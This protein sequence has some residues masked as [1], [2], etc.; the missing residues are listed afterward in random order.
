MA[1]LTFTT[2]RA[3]HPKPFPTPRMIGL[4]C[5]NSHKIQSQYIEHKAAQGFCVYWMYFK[6]FSMRENQTRSG[7]C[8]P[9]AA[10]VAA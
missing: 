4:P 3:T 6:Y 10:Q 7:V 1:S 2:R 9:S 8:L 5:C